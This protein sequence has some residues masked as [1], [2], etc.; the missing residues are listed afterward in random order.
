MVVVRAIEKNKA[1]KEIE[2]ATNFRARSALD[3]AGLL[4][5]HNCLPNKPYSETE[6]KRILRS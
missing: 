1:D 5:L 2:Q 6:A 4:L 3:L